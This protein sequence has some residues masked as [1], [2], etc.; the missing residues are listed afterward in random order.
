MGVSQGRPSGPTFQ[1]DLGSSRRDDRRGEACERL[2]RLSS[3][4]ARR[5]R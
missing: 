2:S 3:G 4:K 1:T 5:I